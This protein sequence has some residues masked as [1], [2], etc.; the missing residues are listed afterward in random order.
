MNKLLVIL[1]LLLT[2][3]S[4]FAQSDSLVTVP[5]SSLTQSQLATVEAKNIQEKAKAYGS[6]VGVGREIGE[7]V[8][9]SLSA[10]SDNA[11]KFADTKIGKI[12]MAIVVW[13][14]V[15]SDVLSVFYAFIVVFVLC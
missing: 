10:I 13:K 6:W 11:A 14:V 8:N 12:S 15:G 3:I 9:S 7:A 2:P 1:A 5:R 4:V